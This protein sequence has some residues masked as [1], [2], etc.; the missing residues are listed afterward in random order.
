MDSCEW[1]AC[2]DPQSMLEFL[3]TLRPGSSQRGRRKLRLYAVA[4]CRRWWTSLSSIAQEVVEITERYAD[5]TVSRRDFGYAQ[6]IAVYDLYVPDPGSLEEVLSL[7]TASGATSWLVA[8]AEIAGFCTGNHLRSVALKHSVERADDE[9]RH[10]ATLIREIFGN[11]F[12]Q[13]SPII[14]TL[15]WYNHPLKQVVRE[16]YSADRLDC[17]R[18]VAELYNA[19]C[20]NQHFISHCVSSS[21]HFKGCWLFD[22]LLDKHWPGH[23]LT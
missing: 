13:A 22:T 7:K 5:G 3:R 17:D 2:D 20:D 8:S 19:D 23:R 11:P 10:Q 6:R 16:L 1:D 12:V 18:L 9:A 4:C 21:N 15:P 14:K